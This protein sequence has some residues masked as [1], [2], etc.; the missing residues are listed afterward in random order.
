MSNLTDIAYEKTQAILA[1]IVQARYGGSG[2]R[3][4]LL[5]HEALVAGT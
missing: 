5:A 4:S 3:L 1:E 2:K